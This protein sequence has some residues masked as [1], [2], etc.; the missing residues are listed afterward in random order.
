MR[1]VFVGLFSKIKSSLKKTSETISRSLTGRKIDEHLAQEI[2]DALIMADVGVE[3]SAELSSKIANR[4]FPKEASDLDVRQFLATEIADLLRP[5]ECNFF[6]TRADPVPR[7]ILVIGVNGNGKTTTTAKMAN[8]FMESGHRPLLV[9]ADTFRAAAVEQLVYW[10]QKIGAEAYTGKEKADAAGL[11]F[12]AIEHAIRNK[13]DVVIVDT[14]GRM[15]NRSDLLAEL[16]KIKRV[17]QKV[18]N[19]ALPET[20]LVIDGITGQAAHSQAEVFRDKIGV[21]G[22]IITKLDSS[23]KGGALISLVKRYKIP[24]FAIGIGEKIQ[25]LKPFDAQEYANAIVD[26]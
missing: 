9:A 1:E 12:S 5:Y 25:D 17:I 3:T 2:E 23:A 15:Q 20:A 19:G 21:N 4:K 26:L 16:E 8:I 14:A 6:E 18:T 22:V 13:N 10:S 7:V 24:I 11:V